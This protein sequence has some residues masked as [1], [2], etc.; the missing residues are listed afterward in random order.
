[1][2]TRRPRLPFRISSLVG[3]ITFFGIALP[4][5]DACSQGNDSE[6]WPHLPSASSAGHGQGRFGYTPAP[7]D[8]LSERTITGLR[9]RPT[10]PPRHHRSDTEK[11]ARLNLPLPGPVTDADF[12]DWGRPST[13]KVELG[14]LLFFDRE[15]SGNRNLSCAT[16]HHPLAG[17]GDDLSLSV[18]EGGTRLGIER[19]LGS[20]TSTIPERVPRNAPPL[21]NLGAR[22]FNRLFHDGRLEIQGN[23]VRSPVGK[24][25]PT[26]LDNALAVQ[27]MLP[28]TAATEMA[29]QRGENPIANAVAEERFAGH[30]GVWDLL[31][32][33][34]RA[35]PTYVA[36]FQRAFPEH[37]DSPRDITFVDAANALAAF[38][39]SAFR[40]DQS[41]F[42]HYLRGDVT[43]LDE[44]SLRGMSLFYGRAR[45][46]RCHEGKFQ[47]DHDF[48][49][50]AMPQIG[51]GKG[52]GLDD[53]DDFGRER[54][55]KR[56]SDRY[57]FRT[58]S[59]RNVTETG[60]WGH[61]G[62]YATLEGIIRHHADPERAL[63]LY[64]PSQAVLTSRP[65]LDQVD[66]AVFRDRRSREAL[67][68]AN[69]LEPIAL[70]DQ[71]V[72]DLV[73]FLSTL[74]DPRSRRLASEIPETVP[75]GLP[76]SDYVH[77]PD[78]K[79]RYRE[80]TDPDLTHFPRSGR[81]GSVTEAYDEFTRFLP[82]EARARNAESLAKGRRIVDFISPFL[83]MALEPK[84]R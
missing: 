25:L 29:G 70:S 49:A 19:D 33:R 34:L 27:A 46:S 23:R 63:A 73:A 40:T 84:P 36:L 58:P 82:P 5:R 62:A 64:D 10:A 53:H 30:G 72:H 26:G 60:P 51:P 22:E 55:T 4:V 41:P 35:H 80:P 50:I 17:T 79:L 78:S 1:M 11:S 9:A 56:K 75:S 71:D 43:A 83:E 18:G 37:I 39:I 66:F 7:A 42:D 2:I 57:R 74:T 21:F 3:L 54:V 12:H 38:Q 52:D 47:T 32:R 67:A 16:C 48:H 31:A 68:R 59:L 77:F 81:P 20:G 69:E 28:V 76:V 65:D 13:A 61:A 24:Q 6:S 44:P 15:L 14:R 45:C 8:T